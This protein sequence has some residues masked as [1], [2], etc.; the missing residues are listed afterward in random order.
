MT[1]YKVKYTNVD[2]HVS[3]ETYYRHKEDALKKMQDDAAAYIEN[4]KSYDMRTRYFESSGR[5]FVDWW[6]VYEE[7]W[8][9]ECDWY[10]KQIEVL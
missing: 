10:V 8:N 4:N 2:R 6:D 3:S 5:L 9:N 7:R 1:I